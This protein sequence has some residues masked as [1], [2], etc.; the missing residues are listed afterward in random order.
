MSFFKIAA[1]Q[2]SLG[3][4]QAALGWLEKAY[5]VHDRKLIFALI[6]PVFWSLQSDLHFQDLLHRVTHLH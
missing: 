5:T 6:D 3:N 1:L 2:A 4:K